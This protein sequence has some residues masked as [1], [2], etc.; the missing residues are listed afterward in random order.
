MSI[1]R[2]AT[3]AFALSTIATPVFAADM[4]TPIYDAPIFEQETTPVE[5]GSGW[6]LRGDV[7]L[8]LNNAMKNEAFTDGDSI[9]VTYRDDV[10][11]FGIGFGHRF[12][13]YFRLEANIERVLSGS[14]DT[15]TSIDPANCH[16]IR[17]DEGSP[18]V[19]PTWTSNPLFTQAD[20][21]AAA[22]CL[23]LN[24]ATYDAS[25]LSVDALIDLPSVKIARIGKFTPFV[26]AGIGIARVNW[27]E[28]VGAKK[29]T[30]L[31]TETGIVETCNPGIGDVQ[32][33]PGESLIYG[34]AVRRGIDYRMSYSLTA[35]VGVELTDKLT[36]DLSYRY[37][38]VGDKRVDY[39]QSGSGHLGEDGFGTHQFK[40]GLRY[41]IW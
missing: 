28:M 18:I 12:N 17:V 7:G 22:G 40:T 24:S 31:S 41:E 26:G 27:S 15:K 5:F 10:I 37:L 3:L 9:I 38:N 30:P 19:N 16:T 21:W 14:V 23:D 34:G 32:A 1:I 25:V 39:S 20:Q 6:Y 36:L 33:L 2:T 4:G 29:C 11:D 35:G 13:D 8:S